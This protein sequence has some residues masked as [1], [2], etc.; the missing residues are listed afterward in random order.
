MKQTR[1]ALARIAAVAIL[2]ACENTAELR[3][4]ELV[5]DDM[6][7]SYVAIGNSITAGYQ[8]GGIND[9]TQRESYA[10]LLARQMGHEIGE[11]WIYPRLAGIGCPPPVSNF[12]TQARVGSGTAATCSLR[13]TSQV[14]AVIHN[15]AVPGAA[16][17]DPHSPQSPNSNLLTNIIL[18]GQSQI[19]RALDAEPTFA[20]IW[21]GNNDVLG[22]GIGGL[23]TAP[24]AEATFRQNYDAMIAQL[25]SG[26]PG[27]RGVL[28]G[29]VQVAQAPILFPVSALLGSPQFKAGFDQIAGRV[30]TSSDPAK[31]AELQIH[32]NCLA[33]STTLVA[34][35]LA[36]QIAAFRND[37]TRSP[38][39][40]AGHPPI[41]SCGSAAPLAPAPVGEAGILT[42]TEQPTLSALIDAYNAH[43]KATADRIGFNG[44]ALA[45]PD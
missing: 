18:G 8:S 38:Q 16:S 21:I 4:V 39:N 32:P 17:I 29:V 25:Q 19:D 34:F 24:T 36:A 12:A 13:D 45:I 5:G 11:S 27:V 33:N 1:S 3:N 7:R 40:R 14:R 10:Y 31:A 41:I 2:A 6:F 20:T 22:H 23:V 44:T 42:E 9:S 37:S 15:V 26:A 30:P 28:I 43:I 35:P